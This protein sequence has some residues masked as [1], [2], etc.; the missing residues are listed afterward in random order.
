MSVWVATVAYKGPL[1]DRVE[2]VVDMNNGVQKAQSRYSTDGT[3]ASLVPQVR[4]TTKQLDAQV[5]KSDIAVGQSLDLTPP[6]PP[7]PPVDPNPGLTAFR[8][9]YNAYQRT[10]PLIALGLPLKDAVTFDQVL[11]AWDSSYTGLV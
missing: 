1:G 9:L 11:A 2:V 7:D 5:Q 3:L 6:P 8:G 10:L 4:A